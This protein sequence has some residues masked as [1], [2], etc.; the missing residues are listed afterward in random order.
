MSTRPLVVAS[1]ACTPLLA[2]R[3]LVCS[4]VRALSVG[5]TST[6]QS[7]EDGG[8]PSSLVTVKVTVAPLVYGIGDCGTFRY[9]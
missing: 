9:R 8:G 4:V 5:A 3:P 7:M 1:V 2:E 6:G